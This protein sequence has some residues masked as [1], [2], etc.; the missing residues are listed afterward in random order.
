LVYTMY[1]LQQT[2]RT[3]LAGSTVILPDY[4]GLIPETRFWVNR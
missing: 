4:S 1:I 3:T 2:E